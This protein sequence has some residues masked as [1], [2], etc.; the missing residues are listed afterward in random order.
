MR[1][2]VAAAEAGV[3]LEQIIVARLSRKQERALP[4]SAARRLVMAGAVRRGGL[5][6]RRPGLPVE[7]GWVLEV[8]VDHARLSSRRPDRDFALGPSDILYQDA[9]LLA[10]AKPAGV[11]TVPTADA[12]RPSLVRA[13]QAWLVARGERPYLAVHQRLDR[14]TSGVVLFARAPRANA[15]LA[16]AF[17]QRR[18]EKTYLALTARPAQRPEDR[19]RVASPIEGRAAVTDVAVVRRLRGGLLVEARPRTGRKH[20]VRIHLARAGLAILGDERHGGEHGARAARLMLHARRLEL[21]HPITA[22]RLSLD[23]PA[24][25]DFRAA[26]AALS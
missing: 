21:D 14:E 25:E 13:V 17:A 5:P 26:L 15:A 20:Q 24:P 1:L 11:P 23:C 6:L 2:T 16:A 12:S 19:F 4:R 10:V 9:A 3:R 18:V 22:A 8:L 7:P